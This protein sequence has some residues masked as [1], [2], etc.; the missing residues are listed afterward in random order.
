MKVK[1]PFKK[2]SLSTKTLV[3]EVKKYEVIGK[4]PLI[5]CKICLGEPAHME[6]NS[7]AIRLL[8][9]ALGEPAAIEWHEKWS[10]KFD[11]IMKGAVAELEDLVK[12]AVA[13][14]NSQ[15]SPGE[16]K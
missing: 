8:C 4:T 11:K 2:Q 14:K 16:A 6:C 7:T 5:E 15:N 1:N 13:E 9:D 12:T 10:S 3:S